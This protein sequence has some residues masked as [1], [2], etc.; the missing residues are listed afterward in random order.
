MMI[1]I[2]K[3][4]ILTTVKILGFQGLRAQMIWIKLN[5]YK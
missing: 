4:L 1:F 2:T 5:D 3:V